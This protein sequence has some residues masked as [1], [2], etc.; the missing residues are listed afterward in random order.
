MR[1]VEGG[2][3][4][5]Q[6]N[7][8]SSYELAEAGDSDAQLALATYFQG[9]G[10]T[11]DSRGYVAWFT[12]AID[13][14]PEILES[15]CFRTESANYIVAVR[16]LANAIRPTPPNV[17]AFFLAPS[18][19]Q[20]LGLPLSGDLDYL[21]ILLFKLSNPFLKITPPLKAVIMLSQPCCRAET[22]GKFSSEI[23]I[24]RWPSW[25]IIV[26]NVERI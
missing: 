2:H 14:D 26:I 20:N 8:D 22:E 25:Q 1:A 7:I 21:V 16:E 9:S 23:K 24:E 6:S 12:R 4:D 15:I 10:V 13:T 18:R 5:A 19:C 3:A 11:H 17:A